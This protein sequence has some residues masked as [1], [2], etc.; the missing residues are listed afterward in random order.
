MKRNILFFG[1]LI[2][3]LAIMV[4]VMVMVIRWTE[5]HDAE[6]MVA[7]DDYAN[8][9]SDYYQTTPAGYYQEHGT[10]PQCPK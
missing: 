10:Y 8:C 3:I 4:T 1:Q 5:K 6:L 7:S 2:L 9:I